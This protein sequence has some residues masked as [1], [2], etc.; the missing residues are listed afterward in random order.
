MIVG[1][2]PTRATRG[3]EESKLFVGDV[4]TDAADEYESVGQLVVQPVCKT[5][6]IWHWGVDSLSAHC[7]NL[8]TDK[9]AAES[10]M[11]ADVA[12][13][14]VLGDEPVFRMAR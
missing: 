1:S 4:A 5:D 9:R 2:S 8:R 12:R 13:I 10:W 7:W 6:A 11:L 14:G 3:S